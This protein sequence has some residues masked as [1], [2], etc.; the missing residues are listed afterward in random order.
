MK[1]ILFLLLAALLFLFPTSVHAQEFYS[2]KTDVKL[3]ENGDAIV[4]N[5]WSTKE[6][7]G[8]EKFLPIENLG[9]SEI[10]DFTVEEKGNPYEF[11]ENWDSDQSREEKAGKYGIIETGRGI[12]LVFGLGEYEDHVYEFQYRVTNMVKKLEDGQSLYW[13]F[14]NDDL[15]SPPQSMEI[16]IE[17]FKPFTKED[18]KMWAFGFPGSIDLE[19]E[20]HQIVARASSSL[21]SSNYATILLQFPENYFNTDSTL[22]KTQEELRNQA[23]EGSD[24][25]DGEEPLSEKFFFVLGVILS[26][27]GIVAIPLFIRTIYRVSKSSAWMSKLRRDYKKREK[28][29]KDQYYRE[30]PYHGNPLDLIQIMEFI[31]PSAK[32]DAMAAI[33]LKWIRMGAIDLQQVEEGSIIKKDVSLLK[34]LKTPDFDIPAEESFF[35][36]LKKAK[37]NEEFLRDDILSKF[38]RKNYILYDNFI[39]AL[40]RNSES[41]MKS[42]GFVVEREDGDHYKYKMDVLTDSGMKL[43]DQN[44]M[45]KNYLE[46]YS[47]LNERSTYNVHL[48]ENYLIFAAFYGIAEEVYKQFEILEPSFTQNSTFYPHHVMMA[49]FYSSRIQSSYSSARSGGGGG[50]SS[51]GGGGGSFGGGSGGGTR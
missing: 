15:S 27:L 19:E 16:R 24:Y 51:I 39:K 37:G 38:F 1:K 21:G 11:V 47:L 50:S 3:L 31:K 48:W 45:F 26:L 49:N 43:L 17:G 18:V 46:D 5:F 42:G 32:D 13:R 35:N 4:K 9:D 2:W 36:L 29:L 30:I 22:N 12:E 7:K 41:R 28:T 40:D 33:L 6:T 20:S 10:L 14:V 25:G 23:F 34:I 8:T 44:I